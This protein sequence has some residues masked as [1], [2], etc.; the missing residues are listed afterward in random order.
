MTNSMT[1]KPKKSLENIELY[2]AERYTQPWSMKLDSNENYLGPSPRVIERLTKL[3]AR[4]ISLYPAYGVLYEKIAEVNCVEIEN[5]AVTNGADEAIESLINTYLSA[6][7]TLIT[8]KPTFAMPKI[9]TGIVGAKYL[10]I[11]Y[12]K[13]WEFPQRSFYSSIN[14]SVKIILITSPNNPTGDIVPLE[15]VEKLLQSF[16]DKL[17][18]LDEVY[19]T[20][21]DCAHTSLVKKYDNL[22]IV[23]SLSKDYG[24][25]GLRVGYILSNNENIKNISKVLSPYT[26]NNIAAIAAIEALSDTK[27]IDFV[28]TEIRKSREYLNE[29]FL[30]LGATVYE[31]HA[32]FILADFRENTDRIYNTLQDNNIIVKRFSDKLETCLRITVPSYVAAQKVMEILHPQNTIVFDMDGVM[33]DVSNSYKTAI[34]KT[35]QKF[36]TNFVDSSEIQA[37]KNLGGFNNDWDLTYYL[38][39]E[40]GVEIEYDDVVEEFQSIYWN[41]GCG[42][43]N[44]EDLLIHQETLKKLSENYSLAVFTGRPKAEAEYTLNRFNIKSFFSKIITMDD[45][46][47]DKQKPDT[48]GL[49]ILKDALRPVELYYLGDTV[50]DMKCASDFGAIA[51]GVLPPND[52]SDGLKDLL[53]L[54]K[55]NYVINDVNEIIDILENVKNA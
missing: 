54:S 39:K 10:E 38:I 26:V 50:D 17:L 6:E 28:R 41:N 43:I 47:K 2:R 44:D 42:V 29:E 9:Y 23:R 24:L 34:Q 13:K 12:E 31:S 25:A 51:V 15:F 14:E 45:L 16:P 8:V 7:D 4:D 32:N 27:Y 46:P 48:C 33:V 5:I 22:A 53:Y 49:S 20:Y 37:V 36:T 11:P 52:K 35:Y 1:I 40:A 3:N 19:A 18:I 30:N 21:S 55:A